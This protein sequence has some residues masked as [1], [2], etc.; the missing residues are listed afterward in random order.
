MDVTLAKRSNRPWWMTTF[1]RE[2]F[3]DIFFDRLR[4]EW[5]RDTEEEMSPNVDLMEK[6]NKYFFT[7]ELPGLDKDDISI[8]IEDNFVTISGK[9]ED[10]REMDGVDYYL[11][12]MEFGSFSRTFRLRKRVVEDKVD[13]TFK[14]GLLTVVMPLSEEGKTR[15]IKVH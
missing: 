1:G 8:S 3:G 4:P 11:K 2:P 13:A 5:K 15:R 9:R 10:K 12:E 7:V 6:D 14:N